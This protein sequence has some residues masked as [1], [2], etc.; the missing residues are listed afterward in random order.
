[1]FTRPRVTY[2]THIMT[3]PR[4]C[5]ARPKSISAELGFVKASQ[6]RMRPLRVEPAW[7]VHQGLLEKRGGCTGQL[8][9]KRDAGVEFV[10]CSVGVLVG[11]KPCSQADAMQC[12]AQ[13]H[14]LR[15]RMNRVPG[16]QVRMSEEET[17]E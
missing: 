6:G 8:F 13:T 3:V 11:E 12:P 10:W 2:P 5:K 4:A 1:M 17:E 14:S 9:S 7:R 15:Q 16:S